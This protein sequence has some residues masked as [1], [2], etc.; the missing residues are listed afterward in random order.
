[1]PWWELSAMEQREELVRLALMPGSNKSELFQRFGVSS[2]NGHKWLRRYLLEG[3]SGLAERSR[4]PHSSPNRTSPEMEAQV[5]SLRDRHPAWGGRKLQRRLLDQGVSG[6]PSPGTI[7]EIL[8]RNGRLASAAADQHRA[9]QR[10][11]RAQPNE[12]WQMDFKGHFA[13]AQDRCHPLGVLDDHSRY[14]VGLDACGD[15]R[16]QTVRD[17][18][19]AVFH[20]YGLPEAMLMD[21]GSPWG[22]AGGQCWTALTVW[23]LRLG[24]WVSHGRPY[25]PQTQGKQERLHRTLK[26]ELLQG[27]NLR[28]LDD[29]Q[30]AFDAWRPIYNHERPHQ[31]LGLATPASR[32]RPSRRSLPQVLPAI[33]YG[34]GDQVRRVDRDGF[35]S[36]RNRPWRVGK[37][38]RGQPV[39]LR[40]TLQDGVF[41]L[42]F[43]AHRIGMVDL[44]NGTADACGFVDNAVALPTTPQAQLQ[45]QT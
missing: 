39:A 32:Y 45:Q 5:L 13:M 30:R 10:F 17:R 43:C 40:A 8:R 1:M 7:T 18:L 12:L 29:C 25:H 44:R 23:L 42:H 31:A 14:L 22:D 19:T 9:F 6:V 4:R 16:E 36:F 20:R 27:R 38:F 21:N 28:D 35:I 24:I 3:P 11:E 37:P 2:S 15:E 33:E 26:A 34:A 41:S